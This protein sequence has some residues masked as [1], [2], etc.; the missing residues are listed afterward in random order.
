MINGGSSLTEINTD[1]VV[2]IPE[3]LIAAVEARAGGDP[4]RHVRDA[5]RR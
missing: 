2:E 4:R 5:D 3:D 1:V